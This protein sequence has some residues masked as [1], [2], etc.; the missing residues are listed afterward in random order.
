MVWRDYVLGRL[1]DSQAACAK[2]VELAR[3][4]ESVLGSLTGATAASPAPIPWS[5]DLR[6]ACGESLEPSLF[7]CDPAQRIDPA[8]LATVDDKTLI[9]PCP[10]CSDCLPGF[11]CDACGT[12]NTWTLGIVPHR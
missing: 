1:G 11:V 8:D 10:V 2:E 4:L 5:R 12:P 7:C 9:G 6:C 3:A